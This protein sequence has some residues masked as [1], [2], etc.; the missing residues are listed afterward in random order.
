MPLD[1]WVQVVDGCGSV[2]GCEG[3]QMSMGQSR[4][5]EDRPPALLSP[6]SDKAP[7]H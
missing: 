5:E 4:I 7:K 3:P 1:G 6:V 2:V